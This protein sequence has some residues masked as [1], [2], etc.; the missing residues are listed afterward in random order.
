M[1]DLLNLNGNI[2]IVNIKVN[3]KIKLKILNH[4]KLSKFNKR[5]QKTKQRQTNKIK[6]F[7]KSNVNK[8]ILSF[9]VNLITHKYNK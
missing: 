9:P 7:N 8:I 2:K 4:K 1:L 6:V 5:T 3:V